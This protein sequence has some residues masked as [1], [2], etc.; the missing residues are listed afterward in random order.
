MTARP[1]LWMGSGRALGLA[2]AS[3]TVAFLLSTAIAEYSD[4]EIQRAAARITAEETP[5]IAELATLRGELRRFVLLADDVADRGVDG[6]AQHEEP[7]LEQARQ[8]MDR[9]FRRYGALASSH[10]AGEEVFRAKGAL[11]D[12]VARFDGEMAAHAWSAARKT[13]ISTLRPASDRLDQLLMQLIEGHAERGAALARRIEWL[14]RR[15]VVAAIGLDTVSI[16]LAILTALMT[17]RVVR[18]YT[19]LVERRAEELELF[20]GRVAHDVLGPLGAARLALDVAAREAPA[21]SRTERLVASGKAGL[22]RAR[23]IADALLEFARAGA[24]PTPGERCDVGEVVR[25]VVDEAEPEAH[26]RDVSLVIELERPGVVACGA[27]ILASIVSNL[28]RNALKYVGDGAGKRV[29]VSARPEG[30]GVRIEVA[31]NGPGLPPGLGRHVFEPYVRGSNST[32][33]GVGLGLATVKKIT[34]A[35]GGRVDVRSVLG[36]GCRFG[37]ELPTSDLP[38]PVPTP[39]PARSRSPASGTPREGGEGAESVDPPTQGP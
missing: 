23:L 13:L 17:V 25:A 34:E 7:Q 32:K 2:F 28:V 14:G 21:G 10:A 24:Q 22:R 36:Q 8:E 20:A 30:R 11:D 6:V 18:R 38:A 35:H 12:A 29:V 31:D 39:V 27:G 9:A 33:P 1:P 4:L 15:S 5:G 37:V 26:A 3:V 19:Q 16:V